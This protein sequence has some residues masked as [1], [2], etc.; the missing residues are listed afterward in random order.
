[1]DRS[2]IFE[3]VSKIFLKNISIELPTYAKNITM[4]TK[5]PDL[6]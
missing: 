2:E 1:M 4:E 3:K 5:I 6:C